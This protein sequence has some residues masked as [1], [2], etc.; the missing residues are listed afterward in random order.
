MDLR[1]LTNSEK[2]QYQDDGTIKTK[3]LVP[4]SDAST[5]AS[6]TTNTTSPANL[7]SLLAIL[8]DPDMAAQVRPILDQQNNNPNPNPNPSP[9]E[10]HYHLSHEAH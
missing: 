2:N 8:D 7:Q 6:T 1:S 10:T 4:E 5:Q 9:V 3:Q